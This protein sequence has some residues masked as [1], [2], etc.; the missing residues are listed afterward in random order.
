MKSLCWPI[1]ENIRLFTKN[2]FFIA[3][4]IINDTNYIKQD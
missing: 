4:S 3:P 1:D 2:V